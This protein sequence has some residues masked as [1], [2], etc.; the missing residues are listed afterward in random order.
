M[1][2][3]LIYR[4]ETHY[5]EFRFI[6]DY[7][8][9]ASNNGVKNYMTLIDLQNNQKQEFNYAF[10]SKTFGTAYFDTIYKINNSLLCNIKRGSSPFCFVINLDDIYE[11]VSSL[12]NFS[13]FKINNAIYLVKE[14]NNPE[15]LLFKENDD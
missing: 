8:L 1:E 11:T 3:D 14:S 15:V 7:N 2:G 6:D 4:N 5:F 12:P 9:I 10:H 13:V